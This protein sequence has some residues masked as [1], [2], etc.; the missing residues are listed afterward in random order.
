MLGT[1]PAFILSQDQTLYE[2][3]LITPFGVLIKFV[4]FSASRSRVLAILRNHCFS[5]R[6]CRKR[7]SKLSYQFVW[8][9]LSS[10]GNL[11]ITLWL[12]F[13][14]MKF[15]RFFAQFP[16]PP[17]LSELLYS[18]SFPGV[19]QA[20]FFAFF[21]PSVSG[22][23][24]DSLFSLPKLPLFVNCF[25]CLSLAFFSAPGFPSGQLVHIT[26]FLPLCQLPFLPFLYYISKRD[27]RLSIHA[28]GPAS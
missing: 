5:F 8:L 25:F 11:S 2:L 13:Y 21:L 19:C 9:F 4:S 7:S 16:A 14:T 3:V 15:S 18:I 28:G 17:A 23:L 24:W 20:L 26:R 22:A 6:N 12:K 10:P 1:P 27:P